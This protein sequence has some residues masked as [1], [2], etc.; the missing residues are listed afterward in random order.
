[1]YLSE[2]IFKVEAFLECVKC[3][4]AKGSGLAESEAFLFRDSFERQ[5]FEKTEADD[6]LL[7]FWQLLNVLPDFAPVFL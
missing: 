6:F 2:E 7:N 5:V 1:L 4:S 3:V